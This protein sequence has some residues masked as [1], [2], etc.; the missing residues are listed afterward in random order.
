MQYKN[1]LKIAVLSLLFLS[2]KDNIIAQHL[3][4]GTKNPRAKLHLVNGL[5]GT[6]G[7]PYE[8]LVVE[9][10]DDSKLGIYSTSPNPVNLKASSIALGFTNYLD[11]N[12]NYSSYEMQ[13]GIWDNVG[14]I[15]RFNALSRNES[16]GYVPSKSYS[17]V[18]SLDTKGHVG[19]NLTQGQTV[20]PIAPS[21]NLHVNGTVRFQNL[22]AATTGGS[23][24]V[25]DANGNVKV[26]SGTIAYRPGSTTTSSSSPAEE[27]ELLKVEV[28]ELMKRI[29]QLEQQ[30]KK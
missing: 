29:L 23:Y 25:V 8:T 3:G 14:F 1:A 20:A 26:S 7:F 12:S 18:L 4:I 11:I 17:N 27:I 15:L 28:S 6:M 19:V 30:I 24:L 9:K 21:A 16:G 10:S 2:V 13:Y 5:E 22:P